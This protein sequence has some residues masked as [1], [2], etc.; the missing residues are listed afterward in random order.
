MIYFIVFNYIYFLLAR[1]FLVEFMKEARVRVRIHITATRHGMLAERQQQ[2]R[3]S[4]AS[5]WQGCR[6]MEEGF[7]I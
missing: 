3:N 2:G 5:S 4:N 1:T 6:G 7:V